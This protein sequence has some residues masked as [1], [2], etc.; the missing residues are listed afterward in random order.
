M[1][2]TIQQ[3][4]NAAGKLIVRRRRIVTAQLQPMRFGALN[5][6]PEKNDFEPE[7][8]PRKHFYQNDQWAL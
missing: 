6:A 2:N 5:K 8:M 1:D 7:A 4:E 3:H